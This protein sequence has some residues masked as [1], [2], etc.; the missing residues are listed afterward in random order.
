MD[1]LEVFVNVFTTVIPTTISP[2]TDCDNDLDSNDTN[3]F[4]EFDLTQK[5][6]EIL[7][8]QSSSDFTLTYFT[9][10]DYNPASEIGSTFTNT[11]ADSQPIYVRV[12]NNLSAACFTDTSFEIVVLK[13]PVLN[14]PP[15]VLEQCDDDFDG[16]NVFNLT[17]I[18]SEIVSNIT[19]EIFTYHESL[20]KLHQSNPKCRR[21][22]LGADS[23]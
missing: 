14:T 9:V 4:I 18:N 2:L 1:R 10:S 11:I 20:A 5:E 13:L 16:V 8:G 6:T 23:K 17:E 22:R 7:N 21:Y 19:T 12:T 15:F 3:G